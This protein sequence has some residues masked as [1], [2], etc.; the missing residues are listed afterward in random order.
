MPI[1]DCPHTF[2]HLVT[3]ILPAHMQRMRQAI[4]SP[5]ALGQFGTR[6]IGPKT[7]LKR[8]NRSTDPSGCYV[9]LDNDTPIYVGISRSIVQRLTDHIKGGDN[10]T[11]TLAYKMARAEHPTSQ[12]AND[13]MKDASFMSIFAKNKDYLTTLHVAF[14]DISDPIE[15]CL[16]EIYC[17]M[18][19]DTC[20]WNTFRT[21]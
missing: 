11:A 14:I 13:A 17:A 1:D 21:H 15:L 19:L 18:Q 10:F 3:E 8:W 20:R 6:G 2:H 12:T 5:N 16:F 9:L 7:I 4:G